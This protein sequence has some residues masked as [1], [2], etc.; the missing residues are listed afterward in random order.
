MCKRRKSYF[1]LEIIKI[2]SLVTWYSIHYSSVALFDEHTPPR[3]S[4]K[5]VRRAYL[6]QYIINSECAHDGAVDKSCKLARG[7]RVKHV[8]HHWYAHLHIVV[9]EGRPRVRAKKQDWYIRALVMQMCGH[10]LSRHYDPP[11][12]NFALRSPPPPH[13]NWN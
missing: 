10:Y 5:Y 8:Y 7:A 9:F 13:A 2:S 11:S 4:T 12:V 1:L 6:P 3:L